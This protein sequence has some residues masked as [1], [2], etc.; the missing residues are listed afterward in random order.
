MRRKWLRFIAFSSVLDER[1]Q[2]ETERERRRKRQR[3][4]ENAKEE[5]KDRERETQ[6]N[7]TN[8]TCATGM[9][10]S[11]YCDYL[12]CQRYNYFDLYVMPMTKGTEK[13]V[14]TK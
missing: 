2:R 6:T 5:E 7:S 9:Y 8:N 11:I 3:A 12:L 4:R 13:F 14:S 10:K 1:K